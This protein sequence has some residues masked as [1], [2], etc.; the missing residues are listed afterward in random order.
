MDA[1]YQSTNSFISLGP[2]VKINDKSRF[3][4]NIHIR[5]NSPLFSD[6]I[7]KIK[8]VPLPSQ[9]KSLLVKKFKDLSTYEV[10]CLLHKCFSMMRIATIH[11]IL[12]IFKAL[13]GSF[14]AD[15]VKQITSL[16]VG[17]KY[18]IPIGDYGHYYTN[19]GK[20]E[21]LTLKT[22]YFE[23][24]AEVLLELANVYNA[25]DPEFLGIIEGISHAN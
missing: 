21:L 6:I 5:Y 13:F 2:A 18:L 3:R 23:E 1:K 25:G 15:K 11:D 12:F 24:E 8:C 16:L 19:S 10:F 20:K 7:D 14:Q 9:R 4:P 22:G 17:A